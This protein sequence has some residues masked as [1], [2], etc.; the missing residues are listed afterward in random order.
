[1]LPVHVS[2]ATYVW[3]C[4]VVRT[5]RRAV[6]GGA[7]E[8]EGRV[9]LPAHRSGQEQLILVQRPGWHQHIVHRELGAR[10]HGQVRAGQL[11]PTAG[12]GQLRRTAVGPTREVAARSHAAVGSRG[13][14]AALCHRG[15]RQHIPVHLIVE[16]L[17]SA[18]TGDQAY[19]RA[20]RELLAMTR[21]RFCVRAR[22]R[23]VAEE[24]QES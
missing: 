5:M 10:T 18:V 11:V 16:D 24:H 19:W 3:I 9:R 6:G 23:T 1:M 20:Q 15:D 21:F 7:A 4:H 13:D 2:S 17:E 22:Q 14:P 8:A 12:T